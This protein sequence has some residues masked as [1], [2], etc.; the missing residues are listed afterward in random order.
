[1][2]NANKRQIIIKYYNIYIY[3]KVVIVCCKTKKK[4]LKSYSLKNKLL[5]F[6]KKN[7]AKIISYMIIIIKK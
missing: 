2:I 6:I 5:L 1:M 4:I 3:I 7:K